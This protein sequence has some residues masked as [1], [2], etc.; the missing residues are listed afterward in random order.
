MLFGMLS[1][2]CT[3]YV[4]IYIIFMQYLWNLYTHIKSIYINL[5]VPG[6]QAQPVLPSDI[7]S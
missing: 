2:E 4:K 1:G 5:R 3:L 7:D 6:K